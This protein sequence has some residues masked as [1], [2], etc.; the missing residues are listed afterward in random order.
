MYPSNGR[1]EY[2][3]PLVCQIDYV[4][5]Y[6]YHFEF[7]YS[8]NGSTYN[9]LNINTTNS[10]YSFDISNDAYLSNYSF[11][12]RVVSISGTSNYTYTQN[13][14]KADINNFYMFRPKGQDS[15]KALIPYTLGLIAEL[16]NNINTTIAMNFVDCNGDGVWDYT[17]DYRTSNVTQVRKTFSCLN[18]KGNIATTIGMIMYKNNTVSWAV[19]GCNGIE[20]SENY[21]AI[22][23]TYYL[24]IS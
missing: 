9:T 5:I 16:R 3:I 1:Y 15:Y 22:Y 23:K 2:S 6:P 11:G 12:C 13:N 21:C 17:W 7:V 10:Y 24:V 4:P 14:T 20:A 19:L 8:I 18:A